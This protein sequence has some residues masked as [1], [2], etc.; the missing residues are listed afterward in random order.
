MIATLR[1]AAYH[2]KISAAYPSYHHFGSILYDLL[3]L[4]VLLTPC[5]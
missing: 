4:S 2:I 1:E 3:P 5:V